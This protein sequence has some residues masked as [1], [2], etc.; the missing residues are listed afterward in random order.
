MVWT[1]SLLFV[2]QL[3]IPK[4][5]WRG[6]IRFLF[7]FDMDWRRVSGCYTAFRFLNVKLEEKKP[8]SV[9]P[10]Q[11]YFIGPW[12]SSWRSA[13]FIQS[14]TL[15]SSF[16]LH[17]VTHLHML[18]LSPYLGSKNHSFSWHCLFKFYFAYDTTPLFR[19]HS[20]VSPLF[21]LRVGS[22]GWESP[23]ILLGYLVL[24][25]NLFS[26]AELIL[27]GGLGV[28]FLI[29]SAHWSPLNQR[30]S[31]QGSFFVP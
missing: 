31:K 5:N 24:S 3:P 14:P 11:K 9:W 17:S 28:L 18:V 6:L 15:A 22:L 1:S 29:S 16:A 25:A 13:V 27:V 21:V 10:S 26:A 8:V 2:T 20:V 12:L 19:N 23:S 4:L 30:T 7:L